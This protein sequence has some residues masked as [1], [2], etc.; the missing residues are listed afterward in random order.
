MLDY[1]NRE[2][3][4]K[5]NQE[6][7]KIVSYILGPRVGCFKER[8]KT[9]AGEIWILIIAV[10][11]LLLVSQLM[12][13]YTHTF[14][15]H[16]SQLEMIAISLLGDRPTVGALYPQ[17]HSHD[18]ARPA[19]GGYKKELDKYKKSKSDVWQVNQLFF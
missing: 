4:W 11:D 17:H 2:K 14:I 1:R 18:G 16:E 13:N 6:T 12:K 19:R 3:W 10:T 9:S 5:S 8:A 7:L 15:A